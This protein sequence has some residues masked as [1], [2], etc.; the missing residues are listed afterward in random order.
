MVLLGIVNNV[1]VRTSRS[2]VSLLPVHST[3]W[4]D[5]RPLNGV[6]VIP[7]MCV[8][9]H[10]SRNRAQEEV[11]VCSEISGWNSATVRHR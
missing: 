5:G 6:A 3:C 2:D 11:I 7:E 8:R 1:N 4:M 9:Y 10:V